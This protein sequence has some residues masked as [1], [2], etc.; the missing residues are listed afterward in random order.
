MRSR[1][2]TGHGLL[3]SVIQDCFLDGSQAWQHCRNWQ[4]CE[5]CI[6]KGL[7]GIR[8]QAASVIMLC[9]VGIQVG[10]V[11]DLGN[12]KKHEQVLVARS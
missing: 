2:A 3:S 7:A 8:G 6:L 9:V 10:I 1:D 5:C 11:F 12:S 4:L